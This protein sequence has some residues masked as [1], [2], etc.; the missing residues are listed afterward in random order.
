MS[1]KADALGGLTGQPSDEQSGDDPGDEKRR[2]VIDKAAAL[3][4][5]HGDDQL[6]D[7]VGDSPGHTDAHEAEICLAFQ[8]GHDSQAQGSSGQRI[9]DTEHVAKEKSNDNDPDRRYKGGFP[10]GVPRQ[11][12]QDCQIGQ[13]QFDTRNPYKHGDEGFN[14]AED[15]GKRRK[16]TE[17]GSFMVHKMILLS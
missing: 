6:S 7:I 15:D 1:S 2:P 9:K 13:P 5:Q 10:P 17:I 16:D 14:V 3:Q 4:K 11:N 12:K 8:Q